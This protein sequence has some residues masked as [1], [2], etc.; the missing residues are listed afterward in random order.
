M[1][2]LVLVS[3]EGARETGGVSDKIPMS[4]QTIGGSPGS[5]MALPLW[6]T[7]PDVLAGTSMPL[8]HPGRREKPESA[9]DAYPD[10]LPL[11]YRAGTRAIVCLLDFPHLGHIYSSAGFAVHMIPV[12]DGGCPTREQF[13]SFLQFVDHQRSVGHPVAV[14]CTA[15]RGRTGTVIAGYLITKGYTLDAALAHVRARQHG[16]VE[17]PQLNFLGDLANR[18]SPAPSR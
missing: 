2:R 8:L 11:R 16:A 4:I 14:H 17:T 7:V 12:A 1:C 15:G 13:A 18:Y 5:T 6:W 3:C 9:L 10:D